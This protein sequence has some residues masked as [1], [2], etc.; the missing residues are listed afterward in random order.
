MSL[1]ISGPVKIK[2]RREMDYENFMSAIKIIAGINHTTV[3]NSFFVMPENVYKH[4]NNNFLHDNTTCGSAQRPFANYYSG[5]IGDISYLLGKKVIRGD[6]FQL[7]LNHYKNVIIDKQ[8]YSHFDFELPQKTEEIS[9]DYH[10]LKLLPMDRL[11]INIKKSHR[12]PINN[13]TESEKIAIETLREMITEAEFRNYIKHQYIIVKTASGKSY[14]IFRDYTHTIIRNKQGQV[15][16]EVCVR[17]KDKKVP[18]TDNV[19]A[20]KTMIETNEE[21]FMKLGN[22]YKMKAV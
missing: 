17:I 2:S 20:F 7:I 18:L 9:I 5:A 14:Q 22:V 10:P 3:H 11:E 19:I 1:E 13:I 16:S 15:L 12:H 8:G 4:I 6:K 21:N